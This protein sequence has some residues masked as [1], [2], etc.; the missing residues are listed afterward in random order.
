[1]ISVFHSNYKS[2]ARYHRDSILRYC[3]R[4]SN[5]KF[6]LVELDNYVDQYFGH[7]VGN[8]SELLVACPLTLFELKVYFDSLLDA[9]QQTIT[10]ALDFNGLYNYFT[11]KDSPLTDVNNAPYNSD[12]LSERIDIK[13][14]PYCN[15]NTV[16]SFAYNKQNSLRRTF[17]WDH[18]IPKNKYP[19]LAISYFNLVPACKVCNFLKEEEEINVSPHMNFNPDKVYSYYVHGDTLDFISEPDSIQ[20]F[21]QIKTDSGSQALKDVIDLMGMDTRYSTQTELLL[22]IINKKRIYHSAYWSSIENII[23]KNDPQNRID[24]RK[25]F[26]SI[27]FNAQDYYKRQ[28]SKLT[29][30]LFNQ[31]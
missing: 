2:F 18:V 22:D 27:H 26:F 4:E 14:C 7:I 9:D 8:F 29:S 16:Y 5:T 13:T 31:T 11:S 15:E 23:R 19:F 1:M 6:R 12:V 28:F 20:L 25:L 24:V 30:D 3:R 17:D 21:L 10:E